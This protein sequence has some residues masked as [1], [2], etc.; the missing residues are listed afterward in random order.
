MKAH[1]DALRARITTATGYVTHYVQAPDTPTFPYVLV[2]GPS[3][4]AGDEPVLCGANEDLNALVG[5]TA[6]A[7]T[8]DGVLIMHDAIRGALC[9]AGRMSE[10]TVAGRSAWIVLQ[11][12]YGQSVQV[13]REVTIP[14]TGGH[15][16][17]GV[18]MYRLRSTP[19]A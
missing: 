19:A 1:I 4:N 12:G 5:L 11:P 13:D 8:P 10:L 7:G 14:A 16:A 9:P 18:E 3:W 6:V 15:P 2:W 17:F